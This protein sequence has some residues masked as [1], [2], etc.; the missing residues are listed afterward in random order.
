MFTIITQRDCRHCDLHPGHVHRYY[1]AMVMAVELDDTT[2]IGCRKQHYKY[3]QSY[4]TLMRLHKDAT[5]LPW[6]PKHGF[7][8]DLLAWSNLGFGIFALAHKPIVVIIAGLSYFIRLQLPFR[9]R[10]VP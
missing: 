5:G 9:P 3:C 4:G 1:H 8:Q 6:D 7:L 10:E 2:D